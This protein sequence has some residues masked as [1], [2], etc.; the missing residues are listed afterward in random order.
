MVGATG[1]AAAG[2]WGGD[3][4][5]GRAEADGGAGVRAA[6]PWPGQGEAPRRRGQLGSHSV[7]KRGGKGAKGAAGALEEK[8]EARRPAPLRWRIGNARGQQHLKPRNAAH[9][10]SAWA[11]LL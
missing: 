8:G 9:F 5:A 6:V 4:A 1:L 10:G 7:E 2:S 3:A 11:P